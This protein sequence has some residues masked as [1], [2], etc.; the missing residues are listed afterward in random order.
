MD[1]FDRFDEFERHLADALRSDADL[2]VVASEPAAVASAAVARVRRPASGAA[3]LTIVGTTLRSPLAAAAVIG[4]LIVGGVLLLMQRG[5]PPVVGHP[6]PTPATVSSP[7]LPGVVAPS[8][9]SSAPGASGSHARRAC[10]SRPVRWAR[11]APVIPRCGSSRA[12]SSSSA[13][14]QMMSPTWP[15]TS[16]SCTTR[17]PGPGPPRRPCSGPPAGSRPRYCATAA[18]WWAMSTIRRRTARSSARR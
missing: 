5:Q 6:S 15:S 14:T 18:C 16:A 8:P 11:R 17:R 10:G 3:R 7:G 12:G 2:S 9:T 13:D 4:V 1:D